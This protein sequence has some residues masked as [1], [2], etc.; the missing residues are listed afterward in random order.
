MFLQKFT[1]GTIHDLY[2]KLTRF[3]S[4]AGKANAN[5]MISG[6]DSSYNYQISHSISAN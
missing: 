1:S 4:K 2:F 6:P 5:P 3:S